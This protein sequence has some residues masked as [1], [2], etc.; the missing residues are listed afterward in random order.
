MKR[1]PAVVC[2]AAML[3]PAGCAAASPAPPHGTVTGRLVLEGG[4]LGAGGQQPGTRLIPGTVQFTGGHH[5]RI[6]VQVNDSGRFTVQLPAG[7]YS[8]SDRSP[9]VLQAGPGGAGRPTWSRPVLVTV[10]PQHAT[11][12]TLTTIVP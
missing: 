9:R 8:V 11:K 4:P 10:T 1:V 2:L 7:R 12:I 5:Q 3:L 6:L